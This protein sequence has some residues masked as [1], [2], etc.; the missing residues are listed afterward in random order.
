MIVEVR[1]YR[2]KPGMRARFL[3]VFRATSL[4]EHARLGIRV[5]GPFPD[6]QDADVFCFLRGFAD[7]DARVALGAAFYEGRVWREELEGVLM[8]MLERYDV[9]VVDDVE[10]A[11]IR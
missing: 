4:A 10:G 3:Q 9:T 8:P 2:T 5:V 11:L 6:T 1:T 7:E